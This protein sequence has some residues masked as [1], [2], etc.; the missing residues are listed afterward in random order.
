M[1]LWS[2]SAIVNR[3][4]AKYAEDLRANELLS[5]LDKIAQS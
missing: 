3:K 5:H 4:Y 1:N 2:G